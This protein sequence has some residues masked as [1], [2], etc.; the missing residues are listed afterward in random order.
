[1]SFYLNSYITQSNLKYSLK[2][3]DINLKM[4]VV[5]LQPTL[6]FII[7]AHV[8]I[9]ITNLKSTTLTSFTHIS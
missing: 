7:I 9:F 4:S 6:M 2:D 8:G 1:M 3:Y 5:Q